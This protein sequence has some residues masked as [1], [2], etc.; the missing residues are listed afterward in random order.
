MQLLTQKKHDMRSLR[1]VCSSHGPGTT[2]RGHGSRGVMAAH[3]NVRVAEELR[4]NVRTVVGPGGGGQVSVAVPLPAG[5]VG[6]A[7]GGGGM[8][9]PGGGDDAHRLALVGR[10]GGESLGWRWAWVVPS[11]QL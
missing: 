10:R 1:C 8:L 6:I 5:A 2:G 4:G 9:H 7:G 11:T 3:V